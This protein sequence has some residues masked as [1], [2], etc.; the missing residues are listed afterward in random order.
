MPT[1][2]FTEYQ[3]WYKSDYGYSLEQCQTIEECFKVAKEMC[4]QDFY[5]TKR[6][7][8]SIKEK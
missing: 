3:C 4:S 7:N 2:L 5:I 8:L 6:V 1:E